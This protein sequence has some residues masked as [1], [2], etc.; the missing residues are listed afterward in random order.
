MK[1]LADAPAATPPL[2][3]E[4]FAHV[5]HWIFDLDNT[6]YSHE[7]KVWP[8]V[9]ERITLF[10]AELFGLDG[11]SSRALQKYYYQ[12]YGT[13][14]KGLMEEHGVDPD[15]FL[16]FAHQI[17]LTLLDP[18]PD[19]GD[20]IAA[21]PGRKLILTNGSR[22]HAENVA[23]KLGILHHFEDIFDIVQAGFTPKPERA[24]YENFLAKHAVDP[25]RAAMFEDI[26]KNLLVPS[27]LGMKTVLIVPKT[28]D[29]FREAWEQTAVAAGHV[30]HVT[31]DLTGFLKPLG[32]PAVQAG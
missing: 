30:H 20:A 23:G 26:E 4:G 17:D 7:A 29:P 16:D 32:R 19:L 1:N 24:T 14:L 8:Q 5:D 12:R 13:T 27:A 22:G 15:D 31:A 21:L 6:L 11:L 25:G 10:L 9:D 2:T 18:N 28:P 3:T